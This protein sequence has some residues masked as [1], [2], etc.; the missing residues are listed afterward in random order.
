MSDSAI[1]Q[2]F[3][4]FRMPMFFFISGYV[5]YKAIHHW[6]FSFYSHRLLTKARV[7]LVPTIVFFSIYYYLIGHCSFPAGFWFTESLFEMFLIYFS[8]A[9]ICRKFAQDKESV[10]II[11]SAIAVLAFNRLCPQL[12]DKYY[13]SLG[14]T[15]KFYIFFCCGILMKKYNNRFISMIESNLFLTL[16]IITTVVL[17]ILLYKYQAFETIQPIQTGVLYFIGLLLV[18]I[19]FASFH[20][21]A[22]FWNKNGWFQN[23]ME[24]VGRRTLDL[25]MI[26]AFLLPNLP[27]LNELLSNGGNQVVTE[28]FIVGILTLMVTACSLLI[29]ILLRTSP[30]LAKW[31]FGVSPK[32]KGLS[33]SGNNGESAISL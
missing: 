19:I 33:I 8:I 26:H 4:S 30:T 12:H 1:A 18:F 32:K 6:T 31:L 20:K 21:S 10:F 7:Q 2:F 5:A 11:I 15:S 3:I 22:A 24:Y 25:Y 28:F 27:Q 9:Y 17:L 13:L 16:S 23:S 29:S 14:S